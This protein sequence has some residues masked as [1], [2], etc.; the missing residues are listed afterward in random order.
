M[1][2]FQSPWV[3]IDTKLKSYSQLLLF[4]FAFIR[5]GII[6]I[7]CD[8]KYF[9]FCISSY[10]LG[11]TIWGFLHVL[12]VNA[13]VW[14]VSSRLMAKGINLKGWKR[15]IT[16]WPHSIVDAT[17]LST[18]YVIIKFFPVKNQPKALAS[19]DLYQPSF[20]ALLNEEIGLD[21][22]TDHLLQK[23]NKQTLHF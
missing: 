16:K 5:N 11:L 7:L 1:G 13:M 10:G 21:Q 15:L 9:L 22:N 17:F 20:I 2:V 8:R 18:Y 12:Y 23:T 3:Y 4:L 6:N 14:S 19:T